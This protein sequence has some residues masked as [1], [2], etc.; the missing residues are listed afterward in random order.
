MRED[1]SRVI[2]ER[3]RKGGKFERKGRAKALDDLPTKVGMRRFHA[4]IGNA[5][6]LNEN[7]APLRRYLERQVGRPWNKVFSE[8]ARHVRVDSTV[9]QH[10]RQHLEDFVA[11]APR[12]D[13]VSR[14]RHHLDRPWHQPLYVDAA[15][16]LLKRTDRLLDVRLA[17]RRRKAAPAPP[18]MRVPLDDFRELRRIDGLWYEVSLEPLP[19]P[20][21]RRIVRGGIEFRQLCSE[22]AID[23]ISGARIPLGPPLDDPRSW[24]VYRRAHRDRR[25]AVSKRSLSGAELK[26]HGL[27]NEEPPL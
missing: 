14:Y 15:D 9:Q 18:S 25:Y 1:M 16:G 22:P 26:R 12:R 20:R 6:W 2:V 3:P 27:R 10:V 4:E 8:I 24:D 11:I 5:K 21:Y 13:V 23:A 7:L 19:E 17:R